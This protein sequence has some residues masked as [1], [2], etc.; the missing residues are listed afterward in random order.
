M[1]TLSAH[2]DRSISTM[3]QSRYVSPGID[4]QA[5]QVGQEEWAVILVL[6]AVAVVTLAYASYCTFSGGDS[7]F[8]FSFTGVSGSCH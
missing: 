6:G 7:S 4:L 1:E 5:R 3:L 8:S 2:G